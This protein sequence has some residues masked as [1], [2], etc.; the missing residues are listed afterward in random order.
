MQRT[1]H[2]GLATPA[3]DQHACVSPSHFAGPLL[4]VIHVCKGPYTQ[5]LLL[6]L[7]IGTPAF[8]PSH[9]AGPLLFV[10]HACMQRTIHT[11]FATPALD[12]HACLLCFPLCLSTSVRNSCMHACKGQYTQGLLLL[13]LISTPAFSAS[14]FACPLLFVIHACM[15][16][17]IHTGLANPALD[18]HA[19]VSS[20][21][22]CWSTS[23]RD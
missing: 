6:L 17:T 3:L 10:I 19:C 13:L 5:G 7:L 2:T 9:F 22:L 23:V 12:Q 11:G 14:H 18:Q 8:P 1:I 16:R 21:P 15:Q 20:F 4:F